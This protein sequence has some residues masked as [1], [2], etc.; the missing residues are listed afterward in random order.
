MNAAEIVGKNL[1]K[2]SIVVFELTVYPGVTEEICVL[3]LEKESGLNIE[4][5]LRQL[6]PGEDHD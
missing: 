5:I 6:F 3:I 2:N 1:R 4:K